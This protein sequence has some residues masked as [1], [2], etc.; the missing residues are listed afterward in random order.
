MLQ[1]AIS[2][3]PGRG[4]QVNSSHALNI[5]SKMLEGV[6]ELQAPAADKPLGLGNR[7][8]VSGLCPIACFSGGLPVDCHDSS[9]D[10]PLGTSTTL[11]QAS[12]N[13]F[14]I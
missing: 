3:P 4:A 13:K 14:L 2:K 9:H 8:L 5:Q 11:A 7:Q 12:S 10:Q 1:Q 6:L